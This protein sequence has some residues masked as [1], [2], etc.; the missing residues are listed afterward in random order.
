MQDRIGEPTPDD[1]LGHGCG[2]DNY[3]CGCQP[4]AARRTRFTFAVPKSRQV[5]PYL[6]HGVWNVAGRR[7]RPG[8]S[9]QPMACNEE[10]KPLPGF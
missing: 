6:S 1:T 8:R 3:W 9:T 7:L 10:T 4:S 2:D 5:W